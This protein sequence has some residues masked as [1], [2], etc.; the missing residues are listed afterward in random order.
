[1]QG[2]Q[3]SRS[4]PSFG[5]VEWCVH[6]VHTTCLSLTVCRWI[7]LASASLSQEDP[8]KLNIRPSDLHEL[9]R[10]C[11]GES[12]LIQQELVK[13]RAQM[14]GLQQEGKHDMSDFAHG[15]KSGS[16]S[17]ADMQRRRKKQQQL[18]HSEQ[19]LDLRMGAVCYVHNQTLLSMRGDAG[20]IV[21]LAQGWKTSADD[22]HTLLLE[23]VLQREEGLQEGS[24]DDGDGLKSLATK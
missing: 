22:V 8:D 9:L 6:T 17:M 23:K 15:M 16:S 19:A 2:L 13:V 7:T 21:K 18:S 12:A 5:C 24:F 11:S 4:R 3:N 20:G 14:Q 10:S 1:M